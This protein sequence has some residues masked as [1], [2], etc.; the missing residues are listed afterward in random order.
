LYG[1]A[2][3]YAAGCGGELGGGYTAGADGQS[4][5]GVTAGD[6]YVLGKVDCEVQLLAGGVGGVAG[7]GD[8]GDRGSQGVY[9][10]GGGAADRVQG[11]V[12]AVGSGVV[13][14]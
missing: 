9:Q 3:G 2:V 5:G 8:T 7:D 6:G 4:Q 12:G 13:D 11:D 1:V 10:Y 14:G